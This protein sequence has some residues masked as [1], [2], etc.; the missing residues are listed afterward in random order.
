MEVISFMTSMAIRGWW[1]TPHNCVST[2][3]QISSI[4]AKRN[5]LIRWKKAQLFKIDYLVKPIFQLD[6]TTVFGSCWRN[7]FPSTDAIV[8]H[9]PLASNSHGG[10]LIHD[11]HG[12]SRLLVYATQLRQ[13]LKTNFLNRSQT[14]LSH[15]LEKKHSCF[16]L[17][18]WRSHLI[19]QLESF[20]DAWRIKQEFWR[21]FAFTDRKI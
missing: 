20:M 9:I 8:W 1:Y 5:R 14:Q 4:G 13:Y 3:K 21:H 6:E 11:L 7:L 10:H 15:S 12:Y 16:R 19:F 2:W 17:I 18:I